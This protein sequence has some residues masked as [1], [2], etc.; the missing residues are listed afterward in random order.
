MA[1]I[2]GELLER[3]AELRRRH[4]D[5]QDLLMKIN[6]QIADDKLARREKDAERIRDPGWTSRAMHKRRHVSAELRAVLRE[7]A[8]VNEEIKAVRAAGEPERKRAHAEMFVLAAQQVLDRDTY[9]GIW[10]RVEALLES[11][12]AERAA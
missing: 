12:G 11:V 7:L 8:E 1:D 10:C 4:D 3:R 2:E 9:M 5:C 6:T